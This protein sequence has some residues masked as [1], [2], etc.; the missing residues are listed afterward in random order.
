MRKHYLFT[1][2]TFCLF[3]FSAGQGEAVMTSGK[4][5]SGQ[6][7]LD[8]PL[9]VTAY[10]YDGDHTPDSNSNCKC[11]GHQYC[12]MGNKNNLLINQRSIALHKSDAEKCGLKGGETICV[13]APG[14][15]SGGNGELCG[16]YEDTAG[17]EGVFDRYLPALT[18]D[19]GNGY[20]EQAKTNTLKILSPGS[21][22]IP[23]PGG[24]QGGKG[25]Q[26]GSAGR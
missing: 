3:L 10:G 12:G 23:H 1:F 16:T 22:P 7:Q 24:C 6:C 19:Q 15:G 20:S 2:M 8:K 4:Q 26:S 11:A 25:S 21:P 17:V 18:P 5:S 13:E 14:G 9:K